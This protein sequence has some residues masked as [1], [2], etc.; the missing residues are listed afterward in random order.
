MKLGRKYVTA[1]LATILAVGI[2]VSLIHDT[3]IHDTRQLP[4]FLQGFN[5]AFLLLNLMLIPLVWVDR[6]KRNQLLNQTYLAS[7]TV[8]MLLGA[9][10]EIGNK[11]LSYLL[12]VGGV[13]LL[14]V[15]YLE[16]RDWMHERNLEVSA[17]PV[18][19]DAR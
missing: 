4:R 10:H 14:Y 13:G 12:G 8:L 1:I 3:S 15:C 5:L 2:G 6:L 9:W 16:V 17:D 18:E 19:P 7:F 11:P